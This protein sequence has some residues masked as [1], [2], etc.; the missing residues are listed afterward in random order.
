ML[1]KMLGKKNSVSSSSS[2]DEEEVREERKQKKLSSAN[3]KAMFNGSPKEKAPT[4]VTTSVRSRNGSSSDESSRR[5]SL[6]M[7]ENKRSAII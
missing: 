2:S 6:P 7:I 5:K 1:K 4:I 3:L